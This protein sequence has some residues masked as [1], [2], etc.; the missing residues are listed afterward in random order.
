L[1]LVAASMV[2]LGM[3]FMRRAVLAPVAR[4]TGLVGRAD[5]D[6]LSRFGLEAKDDFARLSQAIVTMTRQI[7]EDRQRIAA[8][9]DEL[10]AA[11]ER[12][13]ETQGQLV[14]AER[15]AVVG[16]LAA[17]LA[18]EIGNPLA[19]LTGYVEV[20]EDDELGAQERARAIA[21]MTREL[22]RIHVIMRDLLD[23]SRMPSSASGEGDVREA[24]T[25]VQKLLHPQ[26]RLRE[27]D[28]EVELPQARVGVAMQ[29][30]AL[31]QILLNLLL[32]AADAMAGR[33]RIR[34]VVTPGNGVVVITVDDSGPGVASDVADHVFEPFFTTKPAGAGTG[35]GL[36]VCH[37]MV[38]SVGGQISVTQSDLGG[39]RFTVTL[40]A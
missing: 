6:G 22:D 26:E 31:T 23:F 39:A 3:F 19:V 18:H 32:N 10:R 7:D 1:L 2:L 29:T 16:Q 4:I 9:L 30:D 27:V 17:G 40:P 36:A 20:L 33:G 24:M 37:H 12:L 38:T 14:S 25:H 5:R 28:I 21:H 34:V 13:R 35:L 8:Q 15:L 11:H